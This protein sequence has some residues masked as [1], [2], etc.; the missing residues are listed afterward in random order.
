MPPSTRLLRLPSVLERIP[1]SKSELYRRVRIGDFPAP[2]KL[3]ARA[4]AW[5]ESQIEQYIAALTKG[6]K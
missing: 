5:P 4:V 6:G 1:F 3:G 2:V